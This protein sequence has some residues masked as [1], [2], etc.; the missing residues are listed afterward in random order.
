MLDTAQ[1]GWHASAWDMVAQLGAAEGS[2]AHRHL[3]YLVSPAAAARDLSDA[4]HALCAV[5]GDH[6]DVAAEARTHC[7]QPDACQWLDTVADAFVA[8]RAYIAQLAAAVGPLPSTPGQAETEA[9]LITSRHA[10][11]MLAKSERRGCATGAVAAL[12]RDWD[13]IRLMLDQAAA[14]F[15]MDPAPAAFP[16]QA[17]TAAQVAMLGATPATERA[18]SFGAQQLFAQ[19]RGIWDLLEARASARDA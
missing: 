19:H 2:S 16:P 18:V 1:K 3:A 8:E 4:V 6:P 17:V 13:A 15:G 7:V 11:E 14:R 9:A 10:L 5:H 12:V